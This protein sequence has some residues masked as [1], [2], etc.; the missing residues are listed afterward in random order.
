M[1][2]CGP[3]AQGEGS[4]RK[5][6]SGK[7]ESG[8]PSENARMQN[9]GALSSLQK[10]RRLVGNPAIHFPSNRRRSVRTFETI[11][12]HLVSFHSAIH[13]FFSPPA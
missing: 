11:G 3:A 9:A 10:L 8:F 7:E 1:G 4:E 5:A 12:I 13:V 2:G 6:F